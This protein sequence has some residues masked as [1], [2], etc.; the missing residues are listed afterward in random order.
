MKLKLES[1][2]TAATSMLLKSVF[3][4]HCDRLC[5]NVQMVD[6]IATLILMRFNLEFCAAFL[7]A[8]CLSIPEAQRK[9]NFMGN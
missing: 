3:C 5:G 8:E 4:I 2:R 7:C 1:N 6:N 9:I